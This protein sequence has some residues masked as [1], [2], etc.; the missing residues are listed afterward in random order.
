MAEGSVTGAVMPG[1]CVGILAAAFVV[2]RKS[3][4]AKIVLC[5]QTL[6]LQGQGSHGE[7]RR[8]LARRSP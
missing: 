4:T 3:P 5:D 7:D 2:V 8:A 1:V 6:T